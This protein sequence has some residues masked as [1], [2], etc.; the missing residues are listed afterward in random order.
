MIRWT[1]CSL[2]ELGDLISIP[3]YAT[4]WLCDTEQVT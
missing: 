3:Y 1:E 4:I 2:G